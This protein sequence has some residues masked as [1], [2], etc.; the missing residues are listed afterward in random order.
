MSFHNKKFYIAA[1]NSSGAGNAASSRVLGGDRD[2]KRSL[3]F[4]KADYSSEEDSPYAPAVRKARALELRRNVMAAEETAKSNS[5]FQKMGITG[6]GDSDDDDEEEEVV[7]V[8]EMLAIEEEAAFTLQV[9]ITREE[10]EA[11]AATHEQEMSTAKGETELLSKKLAAATNYTETLTT[12]IQAERAAMEDKLKKYGAQVAESRRLLEEKNVSEQASAAD[13]G[14]KIKVELLERQVATLQASGE[15]AEAERSVLAAENA[16]LNDR[17]SETLAQVVNTKEH[18][19]AQKREQALRKEVKGLQDELSVVQSALKASNEAAQAA[20]RRATDALYREKQALLKASTTEEEKCSADRV[21]DDALVEAEY[22]RGEISRLE[23]EVS[24]AQEQSARKFAAAEVL[25][26]QQAAEMS[27][28]TSKLQLAESENARL[29]EES[30]V[31]EEQAREIHAMVVEE[32]RLS[33]VQDV[34]KVKLTEKLAFAQGGIANLQA[35]KMAYKEQAD[36]AC[37]RTADIEEHLSNQVR[38]LT[39]QLET[40]MQQNAVHVECEQSAAF[41]KEVEFLKENLAK[42]ESEAST[43]AAAH[44][45]VISEA[46]NRIKDAEA[47]CEMLEKQ[48]T[49]AMLMPMQ[50]PLSPLALGGGSSRCG[51]VERKRTEYSNIDLESGGL[52]SYESDSSHDG[53]ERGPF[54]ALVLRFGAWERAVNAAR[55][56]DSATLSVRL[57]LRRQQIAARALGALYLLVLHVVLVTGRMGCAM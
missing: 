3:H 48:Q 14:L 42:L 57:M 9:N 21:A 41:Q 30:I 1:Y 31:H 17:L 50:A 15:R 55:L 38:S 10:F 37:A 36:A 18:Q 47:R 32:S 53:E 35:Q 25:K 49:A 44:S 28:L 29:I 4:T 39:E 2:A 46:N 19:I 52:V 11:M 56:G 23:N 34:E 45:F 13:E 6:G 20:S 40:A 33:A 43:T 7:V 27:I 51:L 16:E 26:A 54:T 22:L 24:I 8:P 12:Q 5:L